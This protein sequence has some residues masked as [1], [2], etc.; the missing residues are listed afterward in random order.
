MLAAMV[1]T[2]LYICLLAFT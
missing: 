1:S 2:F